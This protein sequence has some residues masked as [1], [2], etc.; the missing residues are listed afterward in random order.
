M[1]STGPGRKAVVAIAAAAVAALPFAQAAAAAQ[2]T[3]PRADAHY[4]I[5]CTV[6]G[7]DEYLAKRVDANAIQPDRE[8]GG[9]DTATERFN[10]NNPFGEVCAETGPILP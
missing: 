3:T 4:E 6:Y 1:R 2:S 8:P 9:K 10:A 7:T 5:W